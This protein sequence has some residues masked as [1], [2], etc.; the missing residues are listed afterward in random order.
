MYLAGLVP[1]VH[2]PTRGTAVLD[3]LYASEECFSA[4]RVLT[5]AVKS[6]HRA[7]V[8]VSS[9]MVR[10]R[11]KKRLRVEVMR[12]SPDQHAALLKAL[13]V[14]DLSGLTGFT[15]PQAA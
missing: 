10:N 3:R 15:E 2:Q 12:R 5:S 11:A 14:A 9:G 1:L 6:G 8:A 13:S 4:V 7:I